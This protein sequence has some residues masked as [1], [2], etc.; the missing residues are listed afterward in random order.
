[1]VGG[2]ESWFILKKRRPSVLQWQADA[3]PPLL[4]GSERVNALDAET[5]LPFSQHRD[6]QKCGRGEVRRPSVWGETA[7]KDACSK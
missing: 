5:H 1:M 6:T 3:Y 2:G 7:V 4:C